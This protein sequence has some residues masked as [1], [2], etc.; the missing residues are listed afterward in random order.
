MVAAAV[1][2]MLLAIVTRSSFT[3]DF[4]MVMPERKTQEISF[5]Q[6]KFK[7]FRYFS[8]KTQ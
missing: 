7:I 6:A 5:I 8:L 3:A 4:G 1:A 2:V